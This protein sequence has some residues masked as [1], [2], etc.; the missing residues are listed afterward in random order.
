MV[1][2]R[3]TIGAVSPQRGSTSCASATRGERSRAAATRLSDVPSVALGI[4]GIP[5][6]AQFP[7]TLPTFTISGYQ[8]LG[9]PANTASDFDTG[10]TE[11]ADSLTWVKGRHTLKMGMD[12]R[13]ERLN[14]IQ[15]PSPTG[16]FAFNT[17]GSDQPGVTNTGTPLASFMLGQ[18]Q[19]FSIDLQQQ[20]IRNRAHIQEYFIQDS[21]KVSNRVTIA[22]GLRYTL[23]FPSVEQNNQAAV[24]NLDTQQ[25]EFLG[26]D[27][28]PRS[29]RQ[30]HKLNFAPRLGIVA[31]A[32]ER[33]VLGAGYAL[34]WIEQAGITTPFTTP[35]FPFLQTVTERSLD[36]ISPAFTLADGPSVAPIPLTPTAGLGQGVFAVD[37]DLGSGYVQQANISFQRELNA[38][39][40]FEA[41]YVASKI[42]HVGIPDTNLNQ[43][44]V[45]QLALGSALL[46]KVPNPYFGLVPRSSSLGDPTI[47]VAQLM[48][49]FPE[50]TT[51]SL[52]RNNVGTTFYQGLELQ[53]RRRLSRG[54]SYSVSYTRSQLKDDAS[55]VFDASILTGPVA[56]YPV[57]D[58]FDRRRERDYSTGD[59]PHVLGV[60]SRVGVARLDAHGPGDPPVRHPHC[61][62]AADELQRVCRFRDSAA[63]PG[64]RSDTAGG[65][66]NGRSLVQHGGICRGPAV[67]PGERFAQP[68]ARSV[69]SERGSGRDSPRA[70][71]A[72]PNARD[73]SG[74]LQRPEHADSGRAKR[75][76]RYRRLR[77]DHD[78]GG[79]ARHPA[80]GEN[81]VLTS[82]QAALN[83]VPSACR[84]L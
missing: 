83:N 77:D 16:L 82:D 30:L 64:W 52:Y 36:G 8:Q 7:T 29:A 26:R 55:S 41:A 1:I 24:F 23:N 84:S 45:D 40:S 56:N 54:L 39:T 46:Q 59:I 31:R 37:R 17:L 32:T 14:V 15:P 47:T 80:C 72:R 38:N 53:L 2:R 73:S 79:S 50:Y 12:W 44:T 20:E 49:P 10:V 58:S 48:K 60:V 25:L 70:L 74:D 51:V 66:A 19:T 11:V 27:G 65:G 13:W 21:W 6:D 5:A 71:V 67:H 18:V 68:C 42:T 75:R 35:V 3:R 34:V 81:P 43:L 69:L 28:Q 4:P 33:T 76:R 63:E 22:P 62:D 78:S 9:S 57:A 61:G